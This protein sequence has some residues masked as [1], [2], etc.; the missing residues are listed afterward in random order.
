[1]INKN[2]IKHWQVIAILLAVYDIIAVNLSYFLALWF[3]FDGV[4]SKIPGRYL[5][6]WQ[7]FIPIYSVLCLLVFLFFKL[8]KSMWRFASYTELSRLIAA[9]V[10]TAALHAVGI[11]VLFRRMPLS[12]YFAGAMIQFIL[13]TAVRFS[14]RMDL[15]LRKNNRRGGDAT[16]VML[17]GAGNAGQVVLRDVQRMEDVNERII[18]I[19]DDNP[20]KWGRYIDGVPIVGSRETILE[21]AEKFQIKKIYLAIPGATLEQRRDNLNICQDTD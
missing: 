5:H 11:S 18:C 14:Y 19:I 9:S 8:Y 20:N 2:Q 4:F 17:I 13:L 6:A 12:Y 7:S 1:M 10:I 15:L 16:R 21:N 3:R